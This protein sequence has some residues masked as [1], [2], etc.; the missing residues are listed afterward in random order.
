MGPIACEQSWRPE[1]ARERP[2]SRCQAPS[3]PAG[4]GQHGV[5]HAVWSIEP[6][7][8]QRRSRTSDERA[9]SFAPQ[10]V[11]ELIHVR[12]GDK[13]QDVGARRHSGNGVLAVHIRHTDEAAGKQRSRD[14]PNLYTSCR[15]ARIVGRN[16]PA[17]ARQAAQVHRDLR[18]GLVVDDGDESRLWK[19]GSAVACTA[20]VGKALRVGHAQD[21]LDPALAGWRRTPAK[22]PRTQGGRATHR[23]AVGVQQQR[24]S[25]AVARFLRRRYAIQ[26]QCQHVEP[27]PSQHHV[28]TLQR[29]WC[30]GHGSPGRPWTD[31]DEWL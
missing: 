20:N 11:M 27:L 4:P 12:R 17:D 9:A 24:L 21:D 10:V 6:D 16:A 18:I 22:A 2:P 1:P 28:D 29:L 23:R 31:D 8:E 5:H 30:N 15:Q 26:G 13:V 3:D 19:F 25:E 7:G 14:C